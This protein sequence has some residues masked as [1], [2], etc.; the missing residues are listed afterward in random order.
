MVRWKELVVS[1][2]RWMEAWDLPL[3]EALGEAP[4]ERSQP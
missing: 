1:V 4:T 2:E 3:V